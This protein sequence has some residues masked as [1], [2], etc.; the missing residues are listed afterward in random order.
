[1]V[2]K[3]L[4]YLHGWRGVA[5]TAYMWLIL[6]GWAV[7]YVDM[8][9]PI[10]KK[11]MYAV[12]V[13]EIVLIISLLI[14]PRLLRW[15]EGLS[16]KPDFDALSCQERRKFFLRT[17]FYVF[18][19]F[20]AMYIIFY[21]GGFSPDN[22][23]QYSQAIGMR[24]YNDHH[25][26]FHTLFSIELPLR[27][28]GGWF[29]SINLFQIIIFSLSLSYMA[30]TLYEY[31][32][33]LFAKRFLLFVMLNPVTLFISIV[34][35]K[36]VA[37]SLASMLMMTFAVRV[38]FTGGEWLKSIRNTVIFVLVMTAGTLF[39][40]NAILF[41][42]PLFLAVSLYISKKKT[43]AI[44]V[45]FAALI[46][47]VKYPLYD[48]LNAQRMQNTKQINSCGLCMTIIGNA[49][50][51]APER[52]DSEI[53][54]FAYSNAPK[55]IWE[56]CFDV[57]LGW[58]Y[59]R[60]LPLSVRLNNVDELK[61][62]EDDI[63]AVMKIDNQVIERTGW[64]KVLMMTLRCFRE[65]PY[66]ALRGLLGVTAVNYG[67]AGSMSNPIQ[68]FIA[69]NS[70]GLPFELPKNISLRLGFL[71]GFVRKIIPENANSLKNIRDG[72]VTLQSLLVVAAIG[73]TILFKHIFGMIG[74]I[75]LAVI[76]FILARLKFNRVYDWKRLCLA[77]PL[78]THNF[79]TMLLLPTSVF[80]YFYVSYLVLPLIILV[81]MSGEER[82]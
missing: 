62:S 15:A 58:D 80:R 3:F 55:E 46:W 39:R 67:I 17:W 4:A 13:A 5:L 36:D 65:A 7:M 25:P 50:K 74:V 47:A 61:L 23:D 21:P 41:T 26:V 77:L 52:L 69:E 31:G 24:P 81:L 63:K 38:H 27:L 73:V 54:D 64:K 16:M 2:K 70:T 75:N 49:V 20:L 42:L 9:N 29:G 82:S 35:L 51:E 14:C 56:K 44:L 40:H 66:E 30:Y 59:I 22:V 72:G 37:F 11:R 48:K 19:A 79:G 57:F 43:L 6:M 33:Y 1:M 71:P 76:V 12:S 60:F 45:C 53:L 32:N 18:L 78:L 10:M 34:P 28:T 8:S 68:P